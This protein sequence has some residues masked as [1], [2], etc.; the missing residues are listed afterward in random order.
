MTEEGKD[1]RLLSLLSDQPSLLFSFCRHGPAS[2]AVA[3]LPFRLP[4]FAFAVF[5]GIS[6]NRRGHAIFC[7]R[8]HL[9]VCFHSRWFSSYAFPA[10]LPVTHPPGGCV[11]GG[12]GKGRLV[13]LKVP[14]SALSLGKV[15]HFPGNALLSAPRGET[16]PYKQ[17]PVARSPPAP[18]RNSPQTQQNKLAGLVMSD[19]RYNFLNK[20]CCLMQRN[21]D[22]LLKLNSF[23]AWLAEVLAASVRSY[24]SSV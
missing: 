15:D 16:T 2:T 4:V 20:F 1:E 6:V 12:G 11:R 18:A 24:M 14:A 13:V 10:V 22:L 17:E 3:A 7:L 8:S 19:F 21:R 5:T 23:L 9:P